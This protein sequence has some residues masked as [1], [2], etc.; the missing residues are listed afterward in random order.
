M[1]DNQNVVLA[2]IFNLK[3]DCFCH[4]SICM[5]QT[6]TATS[7]VENS[8]QVLSGQSLTF[9]FLS[10]VFILFIRQNNADLDSVNIFTVVTLGLEQ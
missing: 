7:R 5:T 9:S 1:G 10:F 3:L 2:L 8:A 4:E 6:S